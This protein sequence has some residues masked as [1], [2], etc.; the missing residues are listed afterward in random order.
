[1]AAIDYLGFRVIAMTQLPIGP[2][3][4]LVGT[5]DGLKSGYQHQEEGMQLVARI[6]G[7]LNLAPHRIKDSNFSGQT[8]LPVDA[9]LHKGKDGRM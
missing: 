6:A 3:T 2:D 9:E 1:M 8:Q 4:L 7:N 5:P